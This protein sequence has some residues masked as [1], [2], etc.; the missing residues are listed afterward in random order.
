MRESEFRTAPVKVFLSTAEASVI[1]I[2]ERL[3]IHA[4]MEATIAP[5][6]Q[7]AGVG[8]SAWVVRKI[9][10]HALFS[11]SRHESDTFVLTLRSSR[12]D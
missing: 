9:S 3:I 10:P 1:T 12:R 8:S 6:R 2:V 4:A 7:R 5:S 11:Q